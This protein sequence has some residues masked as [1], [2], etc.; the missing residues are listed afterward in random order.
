MD[1]KHL[2]THCNQT[3]KMNKKEKMKKTDKYLE[4][5][6]KVQQQTKKENRILTWDAV[7]V[8]GGRPFINPRTIKSITLKVDAGNVAVLEVEC[9]RRISKSKTVS[10]RQTKRCYFPVQELYI[11]TKN[12]CSNSSDLGFI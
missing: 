7:C 8:N 10:T 1:T 9:Y 12:M 5:K 11:K 2:I 3:Q 4:I 6:G